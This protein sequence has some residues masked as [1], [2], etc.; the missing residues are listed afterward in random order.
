MP[1]SEANS[2]L[3]AREIPLGERLRDIFGYGFFRP[4]T[5]PSAAIY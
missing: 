2:K 5:R 1:D 4:L 3:N